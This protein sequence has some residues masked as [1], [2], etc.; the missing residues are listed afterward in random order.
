MVTVG[1]TGLH[2][3][4]SPTSPASS[5]RPGWLRPRHL[6]CHAPTSRGQGSPPVRRATRGEGPVRA[7]G[8]AETSLDQP[9]VDRGRSTGVGQCPSPSKSRLE[10]DGSPKGTR[11]PPFRP[12]SRGVDRTRATG[13]G[14]GSGRGVGPHHV[15]TRTA[16]ST[17]SWPVAVRGFATVC[18]HLPTGTGRAGTSPQACSVPASPRRPLTLPSGGPGPSGRRA[19]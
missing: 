5:H 19:R 15:R 13:A 10:V 6:P 7:T 12:R 18:V 2:P 17:C 8:L 3:H 4:N 9:R 11:T 1:T 14:R 16:T